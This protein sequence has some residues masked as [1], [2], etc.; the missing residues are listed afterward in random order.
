MS[1]YIDGFVFPIS[2]TH[3]DAYKSVAEQVADI[4][5]KHG[6]TS[7]FE[8]IGN[9][10]SLEGTRSFMDVVE[11]KEDEEVVF[12]W[13]VFPSKQIRDQANRDVPQDPIMQKL[14]AP[15]MKPG[16]IIFDARRMIYGGFEAFIGV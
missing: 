16:Q 15:L 14:V 2:R 13:V 4:W 3:I 6:A 10:L 8:F 5:K 9:D 11:A 7:Y 12:G 1:A